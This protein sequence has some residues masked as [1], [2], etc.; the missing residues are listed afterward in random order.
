LPLEKIDVVLVTSVMTYW[1]P[2]VTRVIELL[3][4][5]Y[6]NAKVVLGGVYATLCY[7]HAKDHSGAHQV[8]PNH[9]IEELGK[10]F[11]SNVE[12]DLESILNEPIDYSWYKDTAYAV[13]K[14]TSGCPF[15]CKY[16]AQTLLNPKF[17]TKDLDG[18]LKEITDLYDQGKR[19]FAFYDDALLYDRPFIKE[20]LKRVSTFQDDI[21]LYTPNGLHA[22]FIDKEMAELFIKAGFKNPIVSL[23]IAS[24]KKNWHEKLT[25]DDFI[26]AASNLKYAGYKNGEFMAYV[27]LGAPL[28]SE[29]DLLETIELAHTCG[30]KI[31]LSEYSAVPGSYMGNNVSNRV[32]NEPLLHNNSIYPNISPEKWDSMQAIKC[33]VRDM[34]RDLITT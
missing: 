8:I 22:R 26:N 7:E 16:C 30:A 14:V 19:I 5:R 20:Y 13:L 3:K 1:Y 12:I 32:K 21:E 4:K 17:T 15:D 33:K 10:I 34:N 6:P 27:L 18:A 25:S 31:S 2:G 29:E 9:S 28:E 24:D 11:G 23:E